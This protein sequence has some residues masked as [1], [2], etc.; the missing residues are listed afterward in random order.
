[1]LTPSACQHATGG[2]ASWHWSATA[3]NTCMAASEPGVAPAE[4]RS[5]TAKQRHVPWY[6]A[7]P[8]LVSSWHPTKNNSLLPRENVQHQQLSFVADPLAA[9]F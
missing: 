4:S 6:V 7:R 9:C 3:V 5:S 1:M 2:C 8:D